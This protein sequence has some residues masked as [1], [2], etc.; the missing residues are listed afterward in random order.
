MPLPA[1]V[2]DREELHLRRIEMRGF[3]RPDGLFDIEGRVTDHRAFPSQRGGFGP[4]ADPKDPLHDMWVRLTLDGNLLIHDVAAVTDASPYDICPAAAASMAGL[5]GLRIARGWAQT[6]KAALPNDAACTHLREILT[7]MA[8][9]AF[10]TIVGD[11]ARRGE[12]FANNA[13]RLVDTCIAY[14]RDGEVVAI[15]FPEHST[16]RTSSSS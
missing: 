4:L 3:K 13:E 11:G 10:Q 5:K 15:R 6:V 8:T 14:R 7:P 9:A 12:A 1:P 16:R 2:P